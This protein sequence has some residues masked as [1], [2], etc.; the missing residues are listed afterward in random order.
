LDGRHRQPKP[1]TGSAGTRATFAAAIYAAVTTPFNGDTTGTRLG[2]VLDGADWPTADRDLA[3]GQS[4]LGPQNLAGSALALAKVVEASEQGRFFISADGLATLQDRYV[5]IGGT[6]SDATSTSPQA[7]FGDTAGANLPYFNQGFRLK[8]APIRN[9]VTGQRDG[10]ASITLSDSTSTTS[11][12]ERP[13]SVGNLANSN[14]NDVRAL[15]E[16]QL[17]R[18]A[19]PVTVC[20]GIEIRPQSPAPSSATLASDTFTRADSTTTLG[21]AE[22]GGPWSARVGTWGIASN[23]AYLVSGSTGIATVPMLADG[24]TQVT[25]STIAG[26]AGMVFRVQDANNYWVITDSFGF[27]TYN[28]NKVVAGSATFMGNLGLAGADGDVLKVIC[29]G[30]SISI[31]YNGV[32]K[33]S[34]TDTTFQHALGVGLYSGAAAGI[35]RWDSFSFVGAWTPTVLWDAVLGME[36]SKRYTLKRLPQGVG[37]TINSR[38]ATRGCRPPHRRRPVVAL[39]PVLLRG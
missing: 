16:H 3:T 20:D 4:T 9:T 5:S 33:L 2:T 34:L 39:H 23:K 36:I 32:L 31:Y 22:T 12:L 7:I 35:A 30:S 10:G 37:N 1:S 17:A 21:T 24:T 27:A 25:I 13:W 26:R 28:V 11:Y 38:R 18:Y 8:K 14:D 19:Q 6:T 29:S 15:L